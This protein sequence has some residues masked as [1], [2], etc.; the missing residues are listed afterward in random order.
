MY[1]KTW[2]LYLSIRWFSD[3]LNGIK[4]KGRSC[5][6]YIVS[7]EWERT[8]K[9]LE[10]IWQTINTTVTTWC[11]SINILNN[12]YSILK[13]VNYLSAAGPYFKLDILL[14]KRL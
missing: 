5:L 7:F 14:T 8:K 12:I 1:I 3:L 9:K 11:R 4:Y 6:T 13:N 2:D 10:F